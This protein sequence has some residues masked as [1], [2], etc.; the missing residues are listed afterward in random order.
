MQVMLRFCNTALQQPAFSG[1]ASV[2][3]NGTRSYD[4][5][6]NKFLGMCAV[7]FKPK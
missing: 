3:S 6:L 5:E 2:L 1:H 4:A 7:G